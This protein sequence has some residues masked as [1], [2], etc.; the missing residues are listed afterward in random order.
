[1]KTALIK[2]RKRIVL[3][4]IFFA[5]LVILAFA[6]FFNG[7]VIREYVLASGKINDPVRIVVIAD[8]HSHIYGENQSVLTEKIKKQ[9]PDIILLAGDIADDVEPIEGT[10]QLLE[11]ITPMAPCFYVTGNHE[12]W[13]GD[14]DSIIAVFERFGVPVLRQQKVSFE[15][16]NQQLN[17]F[18]VDDPYVLSEGDPR[19]YGDLLKELGEVLPA[20]YNILLAHRPELIEEYKKYG[21]DLVVSGHSH[22]GQWRLPLLLNGFYAPDQ[23][24]FPRYAGGIYRHGELIHVVS[25]GLSYNPRLPRIFNPPELVVIDLIPEETE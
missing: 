12:F 21:F 2:K 10:V 5:I 14:I 4:V 15:I 9:N 3:I 20:E 1:M 25:R 22:G 17:L 8:L 7:I 13:S 16:G 11:K 6:A 23:G 19:S 24:F 18:G